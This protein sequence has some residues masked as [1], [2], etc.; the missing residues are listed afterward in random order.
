[1]LGTVKTDLGKTTIEGVP[2][3]RFRAGMDNQLVGVVQ[4]ALAAIGDRR[5]YDELMGLSAAAFRLF[6]FRSGW[7]PLAP[8]L[9]VGYPHAKR[10]FAALG[11]EVEILDC[12]QA[13]AGERARLQRLVTA[14]IDRGT[15]VIARNID[16][17]GRYGVIFGHAS[18]TQNFYCR[19]YDAPPGGATLLQGWPWHLF[20]LIC[21]HPAS[22][23]RL[24]ALRS[25][26]ECLELA[27]TPTFLH[28]G[29][30]LASGDDAFQEWLDRLADEAPLAALPPPQFE[31][32]AAANGWLYLAFTDA[33]AAASRYLDAL[34]HEFEPAPALRLRA[35]ASRYREAAER[36]AAGWPAVPWQA[37]PAAGRPWTAEMRR[38]Q[39][40][41]L[42]QVRGLEA[43]AIIEVDAA[44]HVTTIG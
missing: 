42:R 34:A 21:R 31:A 33:R 35:A 18:S 22:D 2:P 30:P 7:N 14:S 3:L 44:L 20:F 15:P 16:G 12:A 43:Q 8:D 19:T 23:R 17:H 24:T 6:F 9:M 32:A 27:A 26:M 37:T 1:M 25:L 41:V 39:A 11:Y 4:A 13:D 38:A 36:L 29:Q 10:L 5:P 28:A 40:D